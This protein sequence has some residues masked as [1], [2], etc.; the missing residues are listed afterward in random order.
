MKLIPVILFGI[1]ML[2]LGIALLLFPNEMKA[3]V[4][5]VISN[6]KLLEVLYS[7]EVTWNFRLGGLLSIILG[8]FTLFMCVRNIFSR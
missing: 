5:K 8:G 2:G 3:W 7:K 1:F 6:E 4:S